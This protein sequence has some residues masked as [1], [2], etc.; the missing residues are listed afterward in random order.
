MFSAQMLNNLHEAC[1]IRSDNIHVPFG[2]LQVVLVGDFTQLPPVRHLLYGDIG[3]F[4]F[5]SE[6]WPQHSIF[7]TENMRQRETKLCEGVNALSVG[8][9][10][11]EIV[12][13]MTFLSRP[14]VHETRHTIKLFSN[15]LL[16]NMFNREKILIR[17]G[18]LFCFEAMDEGIQSELDKIIAPRQLWLKVGIPVMLLRNL[19]DNLVNC[20]LGKVVNISQ[21][22]V[23]VHFTRCDIVA[24]LT[25]VA[26]TGNIYFK[27]VFF[28][29]IMALLNFNNCNKILNSI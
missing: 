8:R 29:Y 6:H 11:D 10:D 22:H 4:C 26:F 28:T 25:R 7:L 12:E 14:L 27:I 2:G 1:S 15:N 17:E 20:F 18:E 5:E 13:Y 16:V 19:T 23:S 21:E 9:L 24:D 3:S